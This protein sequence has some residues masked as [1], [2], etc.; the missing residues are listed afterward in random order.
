[1]FKSGLS[2]V[3]S[4]ACALAVLAS[5]SVFAAPIIHEYKN[6]GSSRDVI[7]GDLSESWDRLDSVI[8]SKELESFYGERSGNRRLNQLTIDLSTNLQGVSFNFEAAL[9]ATFGAQFF[10]NDTVISNR[11]DDLWW[12]NNWNHNDVVRSLANEL[13]TGSNTL[14]IFW[15]EWCCNGNNSIRFSLNDGEWMQLNNSNLEQSLYSAKAVPEPAAIALLLTGALGVYFARRRVEADS[16][17][18]EKAV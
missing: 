18:L 1:M 13:S 17:P 4:A 5:S 6:F 16:K 7:R 9:D 2:R 14:N 10:L 3:S 15:A 12:G 11:S 8:Y